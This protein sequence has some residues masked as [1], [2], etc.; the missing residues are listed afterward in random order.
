[1]DP[2][3]DLVGDLFKVLGVLGWIGVGIWLAHITRESGCLGKILVALV[4]TKG[5]FIYWILYVIIVP[6]NMAI[7]FIIRM[8]AG[9]VERRQMDGE[10]KNKK[11]E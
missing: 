3:A 9:L 2:H 5:F 10:H 8:I 4:F 7:Q 1:M 11:S 6:I